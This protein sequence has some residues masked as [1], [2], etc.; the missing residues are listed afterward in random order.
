MSIP[1]FEKKN[2]KEELHIKPN[3]NLILGEIKMKKKI[4][5]ITITLGIILGI[6][7]SV[8]KNTPKQNFSTNYS[9]S[10]L[11][12]KDNKV[13]NQNIEFHA[14]EDF[15]AKFKIINLNDREVSYNVSLMSNYEALEFKFGK[16]ILKNKIITLKSGEDKIYD[17]SINKEKLLLKNNIILINVLPDCNKDI[18]SNTLIADGETFVYTLNNKKSQINHSVEENI[19]SK[20]TLNIKNDALDTFFVKDFET[21]KMFSLNDIVMSTP[22]REICVSVC[23]NKYK[24]SKTYLTYLTINNNVV[25][26]NN[27]KYVFF[28]EIKSNLFY[29]LKFKTPLQKGKYDLVAV[30]VSDPFEPTVT[31]HRTKRLTLSVE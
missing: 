17:I 8:I 16:N 19:F 3:R 14:E 23:S 12:S 2:L 25:D 6:I 5:I 21:S 31:I 10:L 15:N 20:K 11:S 18:A 30:C 22:Q 1:N 28:K 4:F 27:S 26:V 29:D 24:N 13:L 9:I 7:F